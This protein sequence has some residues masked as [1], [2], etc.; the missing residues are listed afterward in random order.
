MKF[1]Q[2]T[3]KTPVGIFSVIVVDEVVR[4][5]GFGSGRTLQQ[6]FASELPSGRPITVLSHPIKTQFEAYFKGDLSALSG[7][8]FAQTG[9]EFR[10][11]VWRAIGQLKPGQTITYQALAGVVGRP[12]AV[13]AV[14]TACGQ[15]AIA[16]LIP[17]HR[18]V[19]S[20]GDRSKYA[21]GAKAKQWLLALE[22]SFVFVPVGVTK[23]RVENG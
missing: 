19:G 2:F 23:V 11:A 6:R 18:V 4:V 17:C 9:T 5:A 10:T 8:E 12:R 3:I 22:E 14:G 13:R 7:I 21:Y 20:N 1:I 15:N 16:V